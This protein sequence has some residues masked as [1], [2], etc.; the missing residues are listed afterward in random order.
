MYP[1]HSLVVDMDISTGKQRFFVGHTDKV[2]TRENPVFQ[3]VPL[4]VQ[5]LDSHQ[6]FI[7]GYAST[8]HLLTV[9]VYRMYHSAHAVVE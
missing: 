3:I 4:C 6:K 1:C 8:V 2:D 7:S 5:L 9:Y